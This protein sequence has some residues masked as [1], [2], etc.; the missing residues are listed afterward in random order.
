[1]REWEDDDEDGYQR[2]WGV[3]G[4]S[5]WGRRVASSVPQLI[6]Q[7]SQCLVSFTRKP[8]LYLTNQP[9]HPHPPAHPQGVKF[10]S[11]V[12]VTCKFPLL[13]RIFFLSLLRKK[14]VL[15]SNFLN[16]KSGSKIKMKS[17]ILKQ[18]HSFMD[19]TYTCEYICAV[20]FEDIRRHTWFIGLVT[21]Q[22]DT[23]WKKE[24][25]QENS[26]GNSMLLR[27]NH[28]FQSPLCHPEIPSL[29]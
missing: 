20:L 22:S 10:H 3:Q 17:K 11:Q 1:M 9:P 16:K 7:L 26:T 21:Q 15:V 29:K 25:K 5:W 14:N 19:P 27:F 8:P 6:L 13:K 12:C 2:Q 28:L 23:R 18:K 24:R 4:A